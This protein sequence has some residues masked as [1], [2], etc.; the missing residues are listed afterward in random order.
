MLPPDDAEAADAPRV[1]A[2]IQRFW[3]WNYGSWTFTFEAAVA[4]K[5]DPGP[6]AEGHVVGGTIDLR[7]A[8]AARP[9]S[10]VNVTTKGLDDFIANLDA[11]LRESP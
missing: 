11:T 6:F 1:D 8:V 9:Q 2:E 7:S 3:A 5:G 10:F 4:L